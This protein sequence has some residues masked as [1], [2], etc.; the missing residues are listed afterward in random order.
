M[1]YYSKRI[2]GIIRKR[3]SCIEWGERGSPKETRHKLPKEKDWALGSEV[4][5]KRNLPEN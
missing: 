1:I 3:K 5:E 4:R 2:H